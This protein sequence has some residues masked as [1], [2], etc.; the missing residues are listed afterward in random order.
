MTVTLAPLNQTVLDACES[1][2]DNNMDGIDGAT[3]KEGTYSVFATKRSA[4]NNDCTFTKATGTWDL[5]GVKHVR[6]WLLCTSGGLIT[7]TS[8]IQLGLTDGTNTGYWYLGGSDTYS[9]GWQNFVVDVSAA[10]DAGTK[11]TSMNAIT[12][13]TVRINLS[14]LGKNVD[15]IWIDNLHVCDG[16]YA[17]GDAAT[18]TPFDMGDIQAIEDTPSTGGYGIVKQIGGVSFL[19]GAIYIGD[20]TTSAND[21]YFES[22]NEVII[23]EDRPIAAG[24]CEF[25]PVGYV[26]T[27]QVV[28]FAMGIKSGT[29]GISGSFMGTEDSTQT[30]KWVMDATNAYIDEFFLF[31]STFSDGTVTLPNNSTIAEAEVLDCAFIQCGT[32][33]VNICNIKNCKFISA[34]DV[35][36]LIQSTSHNLSYCDFIDCDH[37]I[38]FDTANTYSL[39]ECYFTNSTGQYDIEFSDPTTASDLVI[40]ATKGDPSTYEIT[41]NGDSVTINNTVVLTIAA[42]DVDQ[43]PIAGARVYLTT[44]DTAA[45]EIFNDLTD[46]AGEVTDTGYN[47]SGEEAVVGWIRKASSA[48]YYETAPIQ[49]TITADG[50]DLVIQLTLDQ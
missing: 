44:D 1:I 34:D 32:T 37:G 36:A 6:F 24:I 12:V 8:G 39:V 27:G 3:W 41:G 17:Y 15:N 35:G 7:A 28:E 9:G 16:I 47:Y 49:G 23:V 31:A 5:S 30:A 43:D 48:P 2:T 42:V 38:E 29:A 46:T 20:D 14:A 19:T 45:T 22:T 21:A 50:L 4:G 33:D 26:D 18:G 11:P 10:V 40:N 25:K 13:V